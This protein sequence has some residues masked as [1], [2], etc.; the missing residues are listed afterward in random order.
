MNL[1]DRAWRRLVVFALVVVGVIEVAGAIDLPGISRVFPSTRTVECQEQPAC[2]AYFAALLE[3][4]LEQALALPTVDL[5]QPSR[6]GDPSSGP[7][8]PS[9]AG[10]RPPAAPPS[11][12]PNTPPPPSPP[13]P[14]TPPPPG[15]DGGG[16]G[17]RLERLER[18]VC[19]LDLPELNPP[20]APALCG[21]P[22]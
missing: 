4:K 5:V 8:P 11:S 9:P 12:P 19:G 13:P 1:S 2:R 15:G 7:D 20:G 14:P 21:R 18:L 3:R 6:G 16:G 17:G 22:D 10:S